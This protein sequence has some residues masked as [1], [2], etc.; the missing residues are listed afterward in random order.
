[1]SERPTKEVVDAAKRVTGPYYDDYQD[2]EVAIVAQLLAEWILQQEAEAGL[3][4]LTEE[5]QKM[6]FYDP[7]TDGPDSAIYGGR[8]NSLTVD[9]CKNMERVLASDIKK[10]IRQKKPFTPKPGKIDVE[11]LKIQTMQS[12]LVKIRDYRK[13]KTRRQND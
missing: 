2:A 10:R 13:I 1:M 5:S 4:E 12:A 7:P 8:M 9:E 3:A 6:G 11:D